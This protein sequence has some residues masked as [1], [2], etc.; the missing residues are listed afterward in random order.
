MLWCFTSTLI[1][2]LY[3][4]SLH[5]WFTY[6]EMCMCM[7][8]IQL[9]VRFCAYCANSCMKYSLGVS[10]FLEEN[11]SLALSIVFLYLFALFTS[12]GFLIFPCNS[13]KLCIRVA[14]LSFS[15]LPFTSLLLTAI[16]KAS[17]DNHFAF[18]HF[19][20]LGMVLITASCTI[21]GTSIYTSSGTISDLIPWIYLSL[22]L[23]NH[24]DFI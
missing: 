12:E 9:N 16:C 19:F 21:S 15:C 18:L 24:R 17:L 6:N 1:L 13:L 11:S 4:S 20:F 2:S 7:I 23:Y 3:F 14:Y 22:P 10:N 5:I 8:Y